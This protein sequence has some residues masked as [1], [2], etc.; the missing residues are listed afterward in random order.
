MIKLL[1][2]H[3]HFLA[4]DAVKQLLFVNISDPKTSLLP[5]DFLAEA[6]FWSSVLRLQVFYAL[7]YVVIEGYREL[8]Y[9]DAQV[10]QLLAR[11]DLLDGLRRF[12]NANFHFQ[13]D[14]LSPKVLDFLDA[15]GSENWTRELYAALKA[16]F[17]RNL[18]I[19]E[20]IESLPK[21]GA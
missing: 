13:E 1:A 14:P 9:Q 7:L 4:A 8:G 19:K 3:R 15:P 6:Q 10:D 20:F 5:D 17:E 12:R 21:R 18:P 2:L 16:F 11:V